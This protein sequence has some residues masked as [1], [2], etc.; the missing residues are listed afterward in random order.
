MS[1]NE[2]RGNSAKDKCEGKNSILAHAESQAN[3]D[4]IKSTF[5]DCCGIQNVWIGLKKKSAP[6]DNAG[7]PIGGIGNN[8]GAKIHILSKNHI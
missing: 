6:A 8:T 7:S 1:N 4:A 2:H 3:L 5:S